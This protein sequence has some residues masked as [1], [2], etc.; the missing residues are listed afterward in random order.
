M[1]ALLFHTD[2]VRRQCCD[3]D[4]MRETWGREVARSLSRRLQQLGAMSTLDDL[5]FLPFDSHRNADGRIHVMVTPVLLLVIEPAPVAT[6]RETT[7]PS[8]TVTQVVATSQAV[9]PS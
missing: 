2:A 3:V 7:M 6:E 4:Y 5:V 9:R 8:V 1:V